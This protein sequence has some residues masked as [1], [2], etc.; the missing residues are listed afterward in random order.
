[1]AFL[2]ADNTT[3][4]VNH[5]AGVNPNPSQ[6]TILILSKLASTTISDF[7]HILKKGSAGVAGD[8]AIF[9]LGGDLRLERQR[10]TTNQIV[11]LPNASLTTAWAW[12]A[13]TFDITNGGPQTYVAPLSGP[14]SNVTTSASDGSGTQV[15]ASANAL[16]VFTNHTPA[17]SIAQ[18]IA[19]LYIFSRDLSIEELAEQRAQ[20]GVPIDATCQLCCE[21]G[22]DGAAI[23]RDRSGRGN[24]GIVTGV[25]L[26]ANPFDVPPPW[27]RRAKAQASA[28]SILL[29]VSRD[30]QGPV[31]MHD[32]RG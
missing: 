28:G 17:S 24:H 1:V 9:A 27:R 31:D 13:W 3:N 6:G 32:M 2:V 23:V 11:E 30:M 16:R 20:R 21:Y 4:N 10:A 7:R 22:S 14:F 25:T 29:F 15:D 19:A 26:A 5:G 18:T 12:Y 8:Y